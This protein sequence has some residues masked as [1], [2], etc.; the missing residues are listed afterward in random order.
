MCHFQIVI[1]TNAKTM[2][3]CKAM[4]IMAMMPAAK[5]TVWLLVSLFFVNGRCELTWLPSTIFPSF[6]F[7]YTTFQGGIWSVLWQHLFQSQT[8]LLATLAETMDCFYNIIPSF[9]T[10]LGKTYWIFLRGSLLLKTAW[11]CPNFV[12]HIIISFKAIPTIGH[13]AALG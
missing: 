8:P 4:Q 10:V 11:V 3:W 6:P 5:P 12:K 9:E 13:F 7:S 1:V 2:S